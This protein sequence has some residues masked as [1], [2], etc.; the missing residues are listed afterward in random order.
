MPIISRSCG[1]Y[2]STCTYFNLHCFIKVTNKIKLH[3]IT[4]A[5]P[6]NNQCSPLTVKTMSVIMGNQALLLLV[7]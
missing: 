5:K 6:Y 4:A 7:D 1:N 2:L 3:T